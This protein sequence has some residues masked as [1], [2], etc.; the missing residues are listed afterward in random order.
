MKGEGWAERKGGLGNE[1][2]G[3]L[4]TVRADL[5]FMLTLSPR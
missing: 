4:D 5:P 2:G 3:M 1:E